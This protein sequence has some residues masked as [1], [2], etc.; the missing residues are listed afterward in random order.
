MK[1]LILLTL[2]T[3]NITL[4]S[5]CRKEYTCECLNGWTGPYTETIKATSKENAA[6]KCIFLSSPPGTLDGTVC[7]LQ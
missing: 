4:L 1:P 2:I 6:D 3:L 7:E 5:S